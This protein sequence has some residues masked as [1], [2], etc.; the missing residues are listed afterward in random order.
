MATSGARIPDLSCPGYVPSEALGRLVDLRDVTSVF[1]G[2]LTPA[3][4][5]ERDHRAPL[6]PETP[7]DPAPTHPDNARLP[8]LED[9]PD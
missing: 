1:P 8:P 4:R 6:R 2:D 5:C 9:E 3:R 7:T